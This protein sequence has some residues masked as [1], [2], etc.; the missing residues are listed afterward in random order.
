MLPAATRMTIVAHPD[1]TD[2]LEA[3]VEDARP[4]ADTQ[5]VT[6]PDYLAFTVWA[7]DACVVVEDTASTPPT[8][9]LLEPVSF[10]RAGDMVLPELVAQ[11][12]EI[13]ATQVPL[14]F[15]GG[16]VLIGDEFVLVGRDYLD[17]SVAR[18][19]ELG[20]VDGFPYQGTATQ[21]E[22]ATTALFRRTFDPDREFHFLRS[23]PRNRAQ[24]RVVRRNGERWLETV[25]GGQGARQ[26]IFH[27]DMFV[28]LA[29]R[30]RATGR[31]VVLVGDPA[32]ADELPYMPA[33]L[34]GPVD[35]ADADVAG[36]IRWYH[37]TSNNCLVQIDG[38]DRQVW[39]PTYGHGD[40]AELQV[41]DREHQR[42]WED[43]GFAVH[44]L[45]DFHPFAMQMG[46][47]HCIKKYLAR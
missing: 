45:G 21:R 9:W 17:E 6:T 3:L 44:L 11:A 35:G 16:N 46:A 27:I 19:L 14:S 25:T 34:R 4:R 42:V 5:I 18:I 7:E 26:P 8:T 10:P 31:Y 15:Q 38:T 37:A 12:T 39:L 2:D 13:Q 32:R 33:L 40:N 36:E 47:L 28:S 41:V 30:D 22:R 29:G 20:A 23:T 1:E 43:L 24:D